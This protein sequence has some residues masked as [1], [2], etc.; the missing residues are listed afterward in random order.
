M[1]AKAII[2][3]GVIHTMCRMCDTRCAEK[4]HLQDGVMVDVTPDEGHPV[5][6]GRL[7]TRG[8]AVI[9]FFY[10]PNRLLHPLKK[11]PDGRFM[12]ISYEQALDE[13]AEKM[14]QLKERQLIDS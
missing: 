7:C 1:K 3:N 2:Q 8:P 14:L 10:H 4:I 5:N 9:D 6:E 11:M 13:I 12:P